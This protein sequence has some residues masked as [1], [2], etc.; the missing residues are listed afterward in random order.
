MKKLYFIRHGLSEFNKANKWAGSSDTPLAP[1]GYTQAKLAGLLAKEKGLSFDVIVSSPLKR[2]HDTAKLFA[3]EI[4]YPDEEIII[5]ELMIE[6]KFGKL[7]GRKDL[8]ASTKYVLN[9][10]AID[11]YDGVEPLKELHA[12]A[13]AALEFLHSLPHETILVVGHGAHGRALRRVIHNEPMHIRGKSYQNA[14]LVRLI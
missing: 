10:A 5:H 1:E 12:R 13:E 14:E 2:A 7:E 4:G 6:R 3:S 9:E 11:K 8:V